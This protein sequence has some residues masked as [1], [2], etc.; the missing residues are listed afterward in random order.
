MQ[1]PALPQTDTSLS[2]ADRL[3]RVFWAPRQSFAA[4]GED[5]DWRD[6]FAPVAIVCLVGIL[7]HFLTRDLVYD[8]AAPV[9]QEYLQSLSEEKRQEHLGTLAEEREKAWTRVVV[10]T[11]SSLVLVGG[12][13]WLLA[14]L[15]FSR[16]VSYRS[17][18]VVKGYASLIIAVEWVLRTLLI[19]VRQNPVVH[20]GPGL[21]VPESMVRSV[22]GQTLMAI[23]LLDLWQGVV[24]GLGLA[25]VA[26]V[27]VKKA[28]FAVLALWFFFVLG[29]GLLGSLV[30]SAG[31]VPAPGAQS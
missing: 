17:L 28:V 3:L 30:L 25:A 1:G 10:G 22:A 14:R 5:P 7:S 21:L 12:I 24:L 8:P 20:T 13:L 23:N 9:N 6:W 2:L 18:L 11:F 4:L 26:Q 27:P 19:L 15:V 29:M 31:P 16:E